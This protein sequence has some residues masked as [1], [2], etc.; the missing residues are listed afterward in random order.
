MLHKITTKMGPP[1][2]VKNELKKPLRYFTKKD[3]SQKS[4]VD[5][6]CN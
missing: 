4:F 2:K 5:L 3:K 6:L 1:I